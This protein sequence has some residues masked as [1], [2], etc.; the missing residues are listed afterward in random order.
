MEEKGWEEAVLELILGRH[1]VILGIM[2]EDGL[3][4]DRCTYNFFTAD[5][6]LRTRLV[7]TLIAI[8]IRRNLLTCRATET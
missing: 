5:L 4:G 7:G 3:S 2:F 1:H 8:E 6:A